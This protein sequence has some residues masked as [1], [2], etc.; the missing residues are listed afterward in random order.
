MPN[1]SAFLVT[2]HS[3]LMELS[4]S[5]RLD[6]LFQSPPLYLLRYRSPE[7]EQILQARF[8]PSDIFSASNK[9][10]TAL[11]PAADKIISVFDCSASTVRSVQ[12]SHPCVWIF[13]S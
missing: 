13:R 4:L 3:I 2:S 7:P 11:C 1:Q 6:N 9:N 10:T 12:T 8:D 5:H